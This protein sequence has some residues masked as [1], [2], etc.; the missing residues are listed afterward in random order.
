MRT[1]PAVILFVLGFASGASVADEDSAWEPPHL[2]R[3][4]MGYD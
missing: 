3:M 2:P 4:D 1:F